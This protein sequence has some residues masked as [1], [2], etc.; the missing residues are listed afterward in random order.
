MDYKKKSLKK[1]NQNQSYEEIDTRLASGWYV[2]A[3]DDRKK[4]KYKTEK[5][6]FKI[7]KKI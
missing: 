4:K 7:S 6:S 1:I 5:V 3:S 2:D